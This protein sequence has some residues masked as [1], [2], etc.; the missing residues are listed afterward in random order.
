MKVEIECELD[1]IARGGMG[2]IDIL[3]ISKFLSTPE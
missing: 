3:R 1:Q 2:H